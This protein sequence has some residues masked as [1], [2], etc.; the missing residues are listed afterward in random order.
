MTVTMYVSHVI[1]DGKTCDNNGGR[2]TM[3]ISH[4]NVD[5]SYV[6]ADIWS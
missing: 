6:T 5:V 2:M 1:V 4:V 3:N